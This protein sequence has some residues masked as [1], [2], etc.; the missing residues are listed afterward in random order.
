MEVVLF[1]HR[2][3]IINRIKNY[4]EAGKK[5]LAISQCLGEVVDFSKY[6]A[7]LPLKEL[8][9]ME[10]SQMIL[11]EAIGYLHSKG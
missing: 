7:S 4:R 2:N 1:L 11:E 9:V 8:G 6:E 10:G 3:D 5:V